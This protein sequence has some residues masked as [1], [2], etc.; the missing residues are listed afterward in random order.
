VEAWESG[1]DVGDLLGLEAALA[2][3]W[4]ME[5]PTVV[6]A[7]ELARMFGGQA[8][9]GGDVARAIDQAVAAGVIERSEGGYLVKSPRLLAIA[10]E[11]ID[12]GIP[13]AAVLE[14]GGALF[15]D[16]DR[17]ARRF[18]DLVTEHVFDPVGEP[19]PADQVPRL[20]E[21]VRRLRPLAAASVDTVLADAMER[22]V[23]EELQ[24]R[25]SRILGGR[26]SEA[27]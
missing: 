13:L 24:V 7:A 21:I 6:S 8:P 22:H 18:V 27:S 12:A 3:P 2:E 16:V 15:A 4:S 1:Q 17:I 25:L 5:S 23:A 9:E 10:A 14:L 26:R 19:L 11:L 20:A